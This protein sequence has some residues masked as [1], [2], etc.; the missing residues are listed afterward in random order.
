M[1]QLNRA[2]TLPTWE[3]Q[4]AA[5]IT[6]APP[7]QDPCSHISEG[8]QASSRPLYPPGHLLQEPS[9]ITCPSRAER[10]QAVLRPQSAFPCCC[11][12]LPLRR[13]RTPTGSYYVRG[14]RHHPPLC[15]HLF[16]NL[17]AG[18]GSTAYG[19]AEM[20]LNPPFWLC[21]LGHVTSPIRPVSTPV[22]C[23]DFC[24]PTICGND[25]GAGTDVPCPSPCRGS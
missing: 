8:P 10:G 7:R 21:G 25:L 17:G 13:R 9:L 19:V 23:R 4:R 1:A 6:S 20:G 16:I 14:G 22:S 5:E 12:G 15:P 18:G 11:C 2:P 3:G 24:D